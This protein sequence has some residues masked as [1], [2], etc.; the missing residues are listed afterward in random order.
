[1]HC[2]SPDT[3]GEPH[4]S[5]PEPPRNRAGVNSPDVAAA[6]ERILRESGAAKG[7]CIDVDTIDGSLACELARRSSLQILCAASNGK[8]IDLREEPSPMPDCPTVSASSKPCRT[9]ATVHYA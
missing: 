3:G 5:I 8:T 1:M 9:P 7:Y 6:A 4:I 2:F